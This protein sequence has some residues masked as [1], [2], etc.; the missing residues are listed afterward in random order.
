MIQ[1]TGIGFTRTVYQYIL[2]CNMIP[3]VDIKGSMF[4]TGGFVFLIFKIDRVPREVRT[5]GFTIRVDGFLVCAGW[6][7]FHKR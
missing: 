7:V 2:L 1:L 6:P 5:H 4:G 3:D